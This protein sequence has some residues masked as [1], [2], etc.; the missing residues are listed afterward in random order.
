MQIETMAKLNVPIVWSL[1]D[2]WAFT[3]G[4]HY[5]QSCDRYLQSCGTCP[6]LGSRRQL[7]VSHWVWR[8]KRQVYRQSN[9]TVVALSHWLANCARESSL[10][11]D[12]R[13][14]VIPNGIDTQAYRPVESKTARQLLN[15]PQ[16]KKL[17]LFGALK[18]TSNKRKG[19]QF[20]EAALSELKNSSWSDTF[21]LVIVG[22]NQ[23]EDPPDFGFKV[24]YLG[25]F[26][27][28]LS[29]ALAYSAVD[30]F[31][32]PSTQENLANTVMESLA[33]GTPC[34]AF[35]IGGM[36]DMI[37]Q[38]E[39]GYLAQPFDVSDLARGIAWVIEDEERY[40]RLSHRAREKVETEFTLD[41]QAHRYA[42]LFNELIGDQKNNE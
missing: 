8:R 30:V 20:L 37:E 29:L 27:D 41:I 38:G 7:D 10:L 16:D 31:V 36:P 17:I 9:L 39:N 15:L 26:S 24:H 19:F 13:V 4:C 11:K 35:K 32:A 12:I 5:T 23:P 6:Q 28:D 2:M 14:E 42:E 22:A 33:C 34:I 1:H 25:S 21:E 40:Q 18:S 3:G